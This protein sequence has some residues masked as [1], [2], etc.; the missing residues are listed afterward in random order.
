MKSSEQIIE[1]SKAL[2]LAQGEMKPA[3]FDKKNPHFGNRYATL[4]SIMSVAREPLA[5]HGLAIVQRLEGP[6]E[7]L[8]LVTTLMHSSGQ[9]MADSGIPLILDKP[10]MQGM[11]SAITY[12]K[13]YGVTAFLAIVADEDD[14]GEATEPPPS[15]P[16]DE[17]AKR[18]I[19]M[20]QVKRLYAMIGAAKERGWTKDNAEELAIMSFKIKESFSELTPGQYDKLTGWIE[21]LSYTEA[22]EKWNAFIADRAGNPNG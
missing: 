22:V 9:W 20:A 7:A 12:A 16:K 8:V 18:V 3:P 14:D 13:R 1:L 5:K 4:S 19:T 2:A 21:K 10:T 17:T 15:M 6:K 11:G